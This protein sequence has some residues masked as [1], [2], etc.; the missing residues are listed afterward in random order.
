ME[1]NKV[2]EAAELFLKRQS[3]EAHPSGK[4]DS[5]GRWYPAAEE[6]CHCCDGIREPSRGWPM[7]LNKHCRSA[8]HVSSLYSVEL[9]AL[10][11]AVK[12]MRQ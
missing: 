10:R 9:K 8:K 2:K 1:K 7:T 3:R 12:E 6:K 4:F 11:S 5:A